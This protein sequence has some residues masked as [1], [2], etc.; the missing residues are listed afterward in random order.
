V[1]ARLF[2][3]DPKKRPTTRTTKNDLIKQPEHLREDDNTMTYS[4][5]SYKG[6]SMNWPA[7]GQSQSVTYGEAA[8]IINC[9]ILT[10]AHPDYWKII[11]D[12]DG[13]IMTP[14]MGRTVPVKRED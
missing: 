6:E 2:G 5:K 8:A 7:M 4:V 12:S 10:G 14:Y 9:S 3:L 13:M 11:R 1:C